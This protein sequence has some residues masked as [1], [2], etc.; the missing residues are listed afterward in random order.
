MDP[1]EFLRLLARYPELR[2]C[3]ADQPAET[4]AWAE[5]ILVEENTPIVPPD[6]PTD[7]PP[8]ERA[9]RARRAAKGSA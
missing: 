1:S 3:L 2:R 7:A 9:Y 4:L 5:R 8:W 6:L